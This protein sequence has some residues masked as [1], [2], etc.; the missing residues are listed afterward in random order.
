MDD[1]T[2]IRFIKNG[3]KL[4]NIPDHQL[5]VD[6]EWDFYPGFFVALNTETLSKSYID[7]ANIETQAVP[8]YTLLG[9]RLGYNFNC[10]GI[11]GQISI[12]GRNLTDQTYV[13]FSE[14]DSGGNAYQPGAKRE[15][16]G[17]IK[18]GF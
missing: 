3:N 8:S 9:A 12:N 2:D 11:R 14:P 6:V 17:N 15:I 13:A 16:F 10:S 1:T 5:Y 18:I 7:G 4:P